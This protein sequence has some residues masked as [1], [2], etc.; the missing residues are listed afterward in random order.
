MGWAVLRY[1][2]G[3]ASVLIRVWIRVGVSMRGRRRRRR[4]RRSLRHGVHDWSRVKMRIRAWVRIGF[5]GGVKITVWARIRFSFMFRFWFRIRIRSRVWVRDGMRN[6]AVRVTNRI[7]VRI[8]TRVWIRIRKEK[9]SLF[10]LLLVFH[11]SHS[12]PA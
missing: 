10:L 5:M 7:S 12:H 2:Y 4:R 6:R 3:V 1:H 9:L 11:Q 8:S